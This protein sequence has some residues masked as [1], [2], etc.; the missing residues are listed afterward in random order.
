MLYDGNWWLAAAHEERL[1]FLNGA[2]DC[3]EWAVH[4]EWPHPVDQLEDLIQSYY[5]T[6][7]T[8]RKQAI[9][10]VWRKV[11]SS[12]P[13]QKP[14]SSGG[15]VWTNPHGFFNGF[16]WRQGSE[17]QNR[18]FLEGYL[19]CMQACAKRP[20]AKFS[21]GVDYYFSQISGYIQSHPE[22]ADTESI[23]SILFR[24]RDLPKN[25]KAAHASKASA[26]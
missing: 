1:E 8:A 6:H 17:V 13:P 16:Y 3:L 18:G 19:W 14:R 9:T 21:Q 24:F 11:L 20:S 23:A 22:T 12:A 26:Q 5:E 4:A 7:P 10:T 25:S 15:E 2:G